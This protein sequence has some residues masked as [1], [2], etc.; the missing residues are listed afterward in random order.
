MPEMHLTNKRP[1]LTLKSRDL[2]TLLKQEAN[3][4]ACFL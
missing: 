1:V 2:V 3:S 4:G